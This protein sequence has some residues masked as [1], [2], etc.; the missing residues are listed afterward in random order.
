MQCPVFLVVPGELLL[1]ALSRAAITALLS[2]A[3]K[4]EVV[5][6]QV[7]AAAPGRSRAERGSSWREDVPLLWP[8]LDCQSHPASSALCAKQQDWKKA[9]LSTASWGKHGIVEF[10]NVLYREGP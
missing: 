5:K 3:D 9:N 10:Q 6:I 8:E 7:K 4:E 2:V 1:S